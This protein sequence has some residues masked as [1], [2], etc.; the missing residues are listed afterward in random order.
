MIVRKRPLVAIDARM[1]EASGIG[2]YLR[3]LLSGLPEAAGGTDPFVAIGRPELLRSWSFPVISATAPI[4]GLREQWQV[5]RAF[6]R[7]R[8]SLLFVPHYNASA[9]AATR[10]VVTVHDLIHLKFP[11]FLPS[12]LALTYAR[13]L[14]KEV[15]PRAR[16]ILTVSENSKRDLVE[17]L[18]IPATKI[19]VTY[20]AAADA[21]HPRTDDEVRP[22]LERLGLNPGYLLYVGNL[23]EFKNVPFLVDTYAGLRVRNADLPPLVLVGRNFISGFEARIRTAPGVIWLSAV[24]SEDLPFLY[25]GAR[26]FI[27]PSLYEG[28]GLPPL[29]AMASGTPVICSDRASLREVVGDAV[30]LFDPESRHELSAALARILR[31]QGL[32]ERLRGAG[33]DRTRLFHWKRTAELTWRVISELA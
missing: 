10:S 2:T 12:R 23:K 14:L 19:T 16:A 24:R 13:L 27:F 25:C 6:V 4:Y 17:M 26:A 3:A 29:E 28:F 8:A 21:F 33:L 9:L 32:R 1:V 15:V 20:L 31:D 30:I 5:A 7:S 11:Q 18:G 22:V